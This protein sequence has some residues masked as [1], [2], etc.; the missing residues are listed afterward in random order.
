MIVPDFVKKNE[1]KDILTLRR[2]LGCS[3]EKLASIIGITVTTVSRWE[4]NKSIPSTLANKRIRELEKIIDKMDGV[5]KKGK[6]AEWL[7]THH[8]ELDND[9]PLEVISKGP[10]GVK[11]VL[12]ILQGIECGTPV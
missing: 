9:T 12:E 3:Q 7:N 11:K 5:I 4:N 6:E 2:K 8:G 1:K 10:E